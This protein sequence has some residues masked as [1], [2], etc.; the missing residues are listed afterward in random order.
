MKRTHAMPVDV[1]AHEALRQLGLETPLNQYR[2][3]AAW[4]EVAGPTAARQ[5]SNLNIRNDVLYVQVH[6]PA[7]KANLMMQR[8]DLC[9][10]LNEKVRAHVI[11]QIVFR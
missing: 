10:R 9:R 3:M 7:L 1:V 8:D 2:L 11:R 6:S 5:T 4:P